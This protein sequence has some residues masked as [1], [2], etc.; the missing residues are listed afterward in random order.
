MNDPERLRR[1]FD[2][3]IWQGAGAVHGKDGS[4]KYVCG[5]IEAQTRQ[6]ADCAFLLGDY[7]TALSSYRQAATEFKSDKAWWHYATAQE[8][9]AICLHCTDGCL[10]LLLLLQ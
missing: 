3:H 1:W 5:S 8:M 4:V 10:E 2:A 9:V 7:S 6:L